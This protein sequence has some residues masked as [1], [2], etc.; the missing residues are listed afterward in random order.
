V[1]LETGGVEQGDGTTAVASWSPPSTGKRTESPG[2]SGPKRRRSALAL[3]G[4]TPSGE[5]DR[6]G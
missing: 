3:I 1:D 5:V 4:E 2:P 6:F